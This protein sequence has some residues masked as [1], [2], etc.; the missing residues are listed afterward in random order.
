MKYTL[1][2]ELFKQTY[3]DSNNKI[4]HKTG[5]RI[6]LFPYITNKAADPITDLEAITGRIISLIEG[7]QIPKIILDDMITELEKNTKVPVGYEEV[8]KRLITT[9]YFTPDGN[10][11]PLNLKLLEASRDVDST[12]KKLAEYIASTLGEKSILKEAIKTAHYNS[13]KNSNVLENMIFSSISKDVSDIEGDAYFRI[14][15]SLK[16]KFNEDNSD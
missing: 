13:N 7:V 10:I 15:E 4:R 8:F 2:E 12:E 6:K 16:E 11:R 14:T 1:S 9:I 3:V 5:S